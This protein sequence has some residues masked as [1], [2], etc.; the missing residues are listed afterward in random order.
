[1]KNK[2]LQ[3]ILALTITTFICTSILCLVMTF[4][5]V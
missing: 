3:G 5:G 2:K 4:I 1:M